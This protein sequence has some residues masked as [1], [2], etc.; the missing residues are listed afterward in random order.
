M[1]PV[2][3]RPLLLLLLLL[4]CHSSSSSLIPG[5]ISREAKSVGSVGL[6]CSMEVLDEAR[7]VQI[8]LPVSAAVDPDSR[9]SSQ[10]GAETS[11][12]LLS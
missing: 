2:L 9:P 8:S 7:P 6:A 12:S 4:S 5:N 3:L 1:V 10:Y 11:R